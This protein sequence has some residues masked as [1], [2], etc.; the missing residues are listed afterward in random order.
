MSWHVVDA[1]GNDLATGRPVRP[2]GSS[3]PAGALAASPVVT[4]PV[5]LVADDGRS[6]TLAGALGEGGLR[7]QGLLGSVVSRPPEL[8]TE[9]LHSLAAT[10]PAG[11]IDLTVAVVDLADAL[12]ASAAVDRTWLAAVERERERPRPLLVAQG[13]AGELEAAVH[14][15]ML[16]G[17]RHFAPQSDDVAE[18]VASGALLWLLGGVVAWALASPG[19][20][21][22]DPWAELVVRGW[23]P[24]GPADGR[25]ALAR[26]ARG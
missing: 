24:L 25:L 23:W 1:G 9:R 10:T 19:R 17:T 7:V 12:K 14:A 16:L 8:E 3:S 15:A 21:P 4:W 2:G 13:R 11:T 22:F 18:R 20:N 6:A 5:R 26:L